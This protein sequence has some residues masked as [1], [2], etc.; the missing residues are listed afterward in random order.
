[1]IDNKPGYSRHGKP[2]YEEYNDDL[3]A[4]KV[5]LRIIPA[6][7]L[8]W[9]FDAGLHPA[10]LVV[11]W[12]PDGQF[13]FLKEF[14][15]G[16]CGPTR[17]GEHVKTWLDQNVPPEIK[18]QAWAD[19]TAFDGVDKLSGE[20]SWVS[21]IQKLKPSSG[22]EVRTRKRAYIGGRWSRSAGSR[23]EPTDVGSISMRLV[24]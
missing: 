18:H 15:L 22:G 3:H 2:V 24:S 13:R 12:L 5:S 7:P 20:L 9:G 16:H 6:L 1:M 21:I 14:Y 8:L 11:Q 4:S 23:M 10:A 19:P 17:F